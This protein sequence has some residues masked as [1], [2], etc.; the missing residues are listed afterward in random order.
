MSEVARSHR[1]LIVDDEAFICR[2]VRRMF[3]TEGH[4]IIEVNNGNRAIEVFDQHQFDLVLLDAMLPGR[5]GFEVCQILRQKVGAEGLPILMLT[6]LEE[7]EVVQRAFEAGATDFITKPINPPLLTA[8]VHY[9]LHSHSNYLDL[10]REKKRL[11]QAQ[12]IARLGYWHLDART[13]RVYLSQEAAQLLDRPINLGLTRAEWLA[14]VHSEDRAHVNAALSHAIEYTEP[15]QMKFRMVRADGREIVIMQHGEFGSGGDQYLLVGTVQDVTEQHRAQALIHYQTYYDSLTELPNR[16]LFRDTLAQIMQE[17]DENEKM[18]ALIFY[19]IDKFS[20]INDSLGHSGGDLLLKMVADRLRPLGEAGDTVAR[21]GTS[22]FAMIVCPISN[23]SEADQAAAALLERTAGIYQVYGQEIFLSA[24]A[25]ITLYPIAGQTPE[26]LLKQAEMAMNQAKS[27]GGGQFQYFSYDMNA[28]AHQRLAF[29]KELRDAV[30]Q[31]QF[32]VYYQPQIDIHQNRI[33]GMEAL[34][35]WAHPEKGMILPASFIP[36]AEE[37]GLI[38]QIG[39]RVMHAACIE[40]RRLIENGYGPLRVGVNMSAAQFVRDEVVVLIKQ[41]LHMSGLA[42]ELLEIE[43]TESMV[44]ENVDATIRTLNDLRALG[45]KTSMD[46]F[47]TG[48]SSLSVLNKLPLD[49][50]KIDRDFI[51]DIGAKGENG[52]LA[53]TIIAMA[54]S[55]GMHIIAEGAENMDHYRFLHEHGV[56]EIQGYLYSPP[57]SAE[58]FERYLAGW[59]HRVPE[60]MVQ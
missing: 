14:H 42:P 5:D 36:A 9:A 21:F 35:R 57:L 52:T 29:E 34:V 53:R 6:G 44:L 41:I 49:T 18:L 40:A 37:T 1:L 4:E 47:G 11:K 30:R 7:A 27:N 43:I 31:N 22:I 55:L 10:Q 15:Y 56:D 50:L 32:V 24:S 3:E 38:V 2:M 19:S 23:V 33:A 59:S 8:R 17:V 60:A 16:R 13:D 28:R 54:K 39:A 45:V 20:R 51:K 48:Y 58:G 12:R 25:G 26:E 46:D